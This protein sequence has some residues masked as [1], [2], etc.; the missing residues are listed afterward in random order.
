MSA[1]SSRPDP[2]DP[3]S[4]A[5]RHMMAAFLRWEPQLMPATKAVPATWYLRR[6][7][8]TG[9]HLGSETINLPMRLESTARIMA[10]I[11]NERFN[12]DLPGH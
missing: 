5:M 4:D 6:V 3:R 10:D 9:Q 11:M 2:S 1:K 8:P 12:A 7:Y